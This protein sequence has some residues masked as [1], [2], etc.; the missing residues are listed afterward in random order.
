MAINKIV[1]KSTLTKA[2]MRNA[3]EYI[4][5]DKKITDRL[6][7]M[8]GPAPD[9]ITWDSVYNAFLDEKKIWHKDSGRMYSHQILSFHK[10]EKITPEEALEFAKEYV[11]KWFPGFQ[12][13]ISVH[14]D[15]DHIHAHIIT[16]TVSYVDG[17]KLHNSRADLQKMKEFTNEM[18]RER[19]LSVAEKGKHFDGT[20]IEVGET[21]AWSKD[22][23]QLLKDSGKKSYVVDCGI[24]VMEAREQS[25]SQEEFIREMEER[26]WRTTWTEKKKHITF[27]NELGEKVRD[28]NL[29]QTFSM[30]ISK[31]GLWHEF[32]RQSEIRAKLKAERDRA[33]E[34]RQSEELER[35]YAEVDAAINGGTVAEASRSTA[36]SDGTERPVAVRGETGR[37]EEDTDAFIRGIEAERRNVN[38]A[39][40]SSVDAERERQLAEEQRL[41]AERAAE[42]AARR[43]IGFTR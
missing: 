41:A 37:S 38:A 26:G 40:R 27:E 30:D 19:G 3:I 22:K 31:E 15:R 8:T 20:E 43:H 2:A 36:D 18:C 23:Y 16:N 32:E 6:V 1:N 10:D 14:Q 42:K 25:A 9:Q 11:D 28:S 21:I 13:I 5:Q 7:Y 24:A 12:S 35:Y 34:R 29:S 39:E 33:E 17:H 4:L